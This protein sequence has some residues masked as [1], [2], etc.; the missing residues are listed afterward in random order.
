M[1]F[2]IHLNLTLDFK[3]T[4]ED[5]SKLSNVKVIYSTKIVKPSPEELKNH[6]NYLRTSLKKNFY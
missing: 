3:N 2:Q 5:V 1:H 6:Q 4:E